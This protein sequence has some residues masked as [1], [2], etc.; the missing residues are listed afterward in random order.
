MSNEIARPEG[1]KDIADAIQRLVDL[2][3]DQARGGLSHSGVVLAVTL[4]TGNLEVGH[5]LGRVPS[6]TFPV[7]QNSGAVIYSD[8][9]H[10]DPRNYINLRA[11]A[12]VSAWVLIA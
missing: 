12:A 2:I 4:G 7:G 6:F 9:P 8:T 3:N 5:Q 10:P 1:Q 11:T